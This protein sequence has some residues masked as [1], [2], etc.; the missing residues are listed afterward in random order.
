MG[1]KVVA[2]DYL[3]KLKH[4]QNKILIQDRLPVPKQ[5]DIAKALKISVPGIQSFLWNN[6]KSV[7]TD[8][9]DGLLVLLRDCGHDTQ[10]TD[11]VNWVGELPPR[12]NDSGEN[13]RQ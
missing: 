4:E 5:S 6:R 9:V 3:K 11:L 7:T 2:L 13:A 10:F 12:R 1:M 8:I